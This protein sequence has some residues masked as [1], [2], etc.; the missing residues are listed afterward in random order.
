MRKKNVLIKGNLIPGIVVLVPVSTG[1]NSTND[2]RT[3]TWF[4]AFYMKTAFRV[5]CVRVVK[6]TPS[7]MIPQARPPTST[8]SSICIYAS[9]LH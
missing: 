6:T 5:S 1:M 3:H 7:T 9:D 8:G 4:V 2:T